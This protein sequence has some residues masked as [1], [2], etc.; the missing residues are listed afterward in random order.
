MVSIL[1]K[2]TEFLLLLSALFIVTTSGCVNPFGTGDQSTGG[3]GIVIEDFRTSLN[4]IES[5]EQVNVHL[6]VRNRG[7]YDGD[8]GMG[9]PAMVELMQIDPTD[10]IIQPMTLQDLG[11][12]LAPDIE[13]NTQGGH[14][15]ADWILTA[16]LLEAGTRKTYDITAR[17]YYQYENIA[18]KSIQFV[19]NEEMRRMSQMGETFESDPTVQT[20]GP[21]TVELITG[22]IVKAN[23]MTPA[24]FQMEIRIRNTGGGQIRGENYPV[25]VQVE[26]P[27]WIIPT[28]GM[29]PSQI[30]WITPMY[31]DVP[32]GV[33]FPVGGNFVYLWD[34]KS[35]DVTCEF[36]VIQP[37]SSKTKG[38][39]KVKLGYIYSVDDTTQVTVKGKEQF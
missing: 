21:L 8:L 34:G 39:F 3:P 7:D 32:A 28:E 31:N 30:N 1:N 23:E 19:T 10:W 17:V 12:I 4:L 14:A 38:E 22:N 33:P 35:S 27:T 11:T 2:K 25:A 20:G 9:A 37:P 24:R 36:E 18:T 5:G 13:S 15:T 29:C 26:Y 6:D 16:P